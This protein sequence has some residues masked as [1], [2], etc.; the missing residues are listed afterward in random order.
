MYPAVPDGGESAPPPRA[1][2]GLPGE[3]ADAPSVASGSIRRA[4]RTMNRCVI[5]RG[6]HPGDHGR[7]LAELAYEHSM[8]D[9]YR[10]RLATAPY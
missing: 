1:L 6:A 4:I 5:L 3:A 10:R 9:R 8:S 2:V 7:P